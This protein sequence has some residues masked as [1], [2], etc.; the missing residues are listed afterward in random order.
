MR[1][2]T[3]PGQRDCIRLHLDDGEILALY[4]A[5]ESAGLSPGQAL[6]IADASDQRALCT[7][8][9]VLQRAMRGSPEGYTGAFVNRADLDRFS[10]HLLDD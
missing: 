7:F 10:G 4:A 5:P 1:L 8:M 2:S 3:P 6:L 9:D